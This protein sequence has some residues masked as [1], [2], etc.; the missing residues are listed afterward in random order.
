MIARIA[1]VIVAWGT[2]PAYAHAPFGADGVAGGLL[3]PLSVPSHLI[4]LI[5]LALLIAQG[6]ICARNVLLTIFA[7]A[8]V[9]GL[10]ALALAVGPTPAAEIALAGAAMAGALVALARPVPMTVAAALAATI[11][12]AIGLDS[13]PESIS[14]AIAIAALIGTAFTSALILLAVIE[15]ARRLTGDWQ[16]IG[17]RIAGSWI[18]ASALM[19]LALQIAGS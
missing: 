9:G 19:A 2:A 10:A 13:P 15:T 6:P 17:V 12:A 8:L 14:L 3:H 1:A 18:A 5:A 4:A 11:G 16:R 7:L